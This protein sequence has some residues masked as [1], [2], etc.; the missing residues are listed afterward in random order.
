LVVVETCPAIP[1]AL[2]EPCA[3]PARELV[4]NGDLARAY[5]D[6]TECV[7][8]STLKLRAIRELAVC[9]LQKETTR[10][11]RPSR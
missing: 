7:D 4:T 8:E 10:G 1:V 9:R 5:L 6:A 3:P 11:S 2:T